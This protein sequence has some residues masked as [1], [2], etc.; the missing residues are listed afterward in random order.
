MD[1]AEIFVT[2]VGIA[3]IIW[4]IWFFFLSKGLLKTK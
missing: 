4:T 2:I 3:A 1:R